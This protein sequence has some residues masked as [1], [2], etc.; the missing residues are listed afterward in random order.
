MKIFYVD[1]VY[2]LFL[3]LLLDGDTA[4]NL[5]IF[6][7]SISKNIVEKFRNTY[8]FS[9]IEYKIKYGKY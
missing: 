8:Q 2:S 3:G 1:T 7:M 5:Y 9:K 4:N 6:D